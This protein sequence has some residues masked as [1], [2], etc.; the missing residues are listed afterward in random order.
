MDTWNKVGSSGQFVQQGVGG[1]ATAIG[2]KQATGTR[3]PEEVPGYPGADKRQQTCRSPRRCSVAEMLT[4][5]NRPS[6]WRRCAICAW[7]TCVPPSVRWPKQ[8][9]QFLFSKV[10]METSF[11]NTTGLYWPA[12]AMAETGSDSTRPATA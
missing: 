5:P 7:N 6:A 11:Q 2:E 8:D 3:S 9:I 1:M 10:A 12:G 4:S